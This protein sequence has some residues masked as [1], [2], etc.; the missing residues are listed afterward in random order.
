MIRSHETDSTAL[1]FDKTRYYR[2]GCDAVVLNK[3]GAGVCLI[4]DGSGGIGLASVNSSGFQYWNFE[5]YGNYNW[6]GADPVT[7]WPEADQFMWRK[8]GQ[9]EQNGNLRQ[10]SP[11]CYDGGILD[12]AN[13]PADALYLPDR[14]LFNW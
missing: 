3:D 14:G 12:C 9:H 6:P 4:V 10:F 11:K 7:L 2:N 1:G 13:S 5:I 8:L